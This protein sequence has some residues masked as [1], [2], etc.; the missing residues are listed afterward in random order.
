M[1]DPKKQTTSPISK[2]R[3]STP[4]LG[5]NGRAAVSFKGL[6]P[7][8]AFRIFRPRTLFYKD[9]PRLTPPA[10]QWTP[11]AIKPPRQWSFETRDIWLSDASTR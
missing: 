10:I 5:I 4:Y 7:G 9:W 3:G 2:S 11:P 8:G 1:T 6:S